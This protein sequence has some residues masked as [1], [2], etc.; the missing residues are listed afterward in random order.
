MASA[1]LANS[2]VN[3]SHRLIWNVK[4]ARA[5]PVAISRAARM[6]V[7][8]APTS[9]TNMTGFF[10]M[11][12]GFSLTNES[13]SARFTIGGSNSGRA[14]EP[15]LGISVTGSTAGGVIVVAIG[16]SAP[17]SACV[18]QEMFH[19]RPQRECREESERPH[20]HDHTH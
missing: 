16:S 6:V 19:N 4:P 10:I 2:T 9:T 3:H 8:A 1:K 20:D 7:I 15:F 13:L 5:A 14:R 17:K 11:V 18:H 12:R